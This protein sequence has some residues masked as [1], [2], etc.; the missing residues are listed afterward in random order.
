MNKQKSAF[1]SLR[2]LL[3]NAVRYQTETATFNAELQQL[4][5]PREHSMNICRILDEYASKIKAILIKSSL[6]V[7]ELD[8]VNCNVPPNTIDCLQLELNI[9]N[10]IID[11]VSQNVQHKVNIHKDDIP[12]LVKELKTIKGIMDNINYD[13][14]YE[15]IK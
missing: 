5:L 15:E 11:G 1:S 13:K 9:A 3:I 6:T 10:E 8:K 12:I 2:F 7:N 14:K 4:G